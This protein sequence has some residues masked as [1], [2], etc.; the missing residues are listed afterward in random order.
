MI[1]LPPMHTGM[2]NTSLYAIIFILIIYCNCMAFPL[3]ITRLLKGETLVVRIQK[4]WRFGQRLF[5]V[6]L[7]QGSFAIRSLAMVPVEPE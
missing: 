5:Y 6:S 4:F 7:S 3:S 1:E 2:L